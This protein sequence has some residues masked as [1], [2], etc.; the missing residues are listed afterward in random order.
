LEAAERALAI[1]P[2]IAEA[3]CVR[4]RHL[5][6][7]G[8]TNEADAAIALALQLDPES[9]EVNKEAARQCML[10]RRVQEATGYYQKAAS[11]LESDFHSW[12]I[13]ITCYRAAGDPEGVLHAARMTVERSERALAEDPSNG[14]ALGMIAA[15]L[16][17]MGEKQRARERIDRAILLDPDNANLRYNFACVLANELNDP[18]AA[19]DLLEPAFA[20][21]GQAMVRFAEADPDFDPIRAHPRFVAAISEARARLGLAK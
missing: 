3:H 16:A 15:G 2:N 12:G 17:L 8:K 5:S 13:L 14:S 19:L 18:D 6:N 4:A 11:L 9:W 10:Y 21:A 20:R 7:Q 1:D